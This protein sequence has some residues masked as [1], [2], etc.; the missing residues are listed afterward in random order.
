MLGGFGNTRG[1]HCIRQHARQRDDHD[2]EL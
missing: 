2:S 1:V